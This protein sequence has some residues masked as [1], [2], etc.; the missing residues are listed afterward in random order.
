MSITNNKTPLTPIRL[1]Q[2]PIADTNT[3]QNFNKAF[4]PLI[5]NSFN[6][7]KP[8]NFLGDNKFSSSKN[9]FHPIEFYALG[10]IPSG[11]V[12]PMFQWNKGIKSTSNNIIERNVLSINTAKFNR[13]YNYKHLS[14]LSQQNVT[15]NNYMKPIK[16]YKTSEK[17]NLPQNTTNFETYKIMKE[18][19]FSKD[20]QSTIAKGKYLN[21]SD[22]IKEKENTIKNKNEPKIQKIEEMKTCIGKNDIKN[23]RKNK[24]STGFFFKDPN[25]YSKKLL[26]NNTYGFEQNN[27][28]MIKPK[29]WKFGEKV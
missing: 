12:Y 25:D 21:K 27:I 4:T 14:S 20:I 10:K 13:L 29:K 26:M 6:R 18:K 28:Q 8:S 1:T 22:F 3:V 9:S 16:L 17:Y 15:E 23:D 2:S 7:N 5:S 11:T 24:T 19:L